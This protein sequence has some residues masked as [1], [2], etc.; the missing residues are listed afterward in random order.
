LAS[1]GFSSPSGGHPDQES[2]SQAGKQADGPPE[3]AGG[4]CGDLNT[5]IY[6]SVAEQIESR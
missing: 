1:D 6:V 4:G 3:N 5:S 2:E